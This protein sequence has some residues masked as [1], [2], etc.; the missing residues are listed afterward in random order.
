MRTTTITGKGQVTIP[1]EIRQR[2]G[3]VEGE[4]LEVQLEADTV[5]LRRAQSVIARTAGIFADSGQ[6]RSAEEM[7]EAA[8]TAIA[9]EAEARSHPEPV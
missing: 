5:C 8:E 7:R 3:L 4:R 6:T 2:L 1:I 9:L